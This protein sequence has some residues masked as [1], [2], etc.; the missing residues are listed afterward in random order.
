M[1]KKSSGQN[2]EKAH[3][4]VLTGFLGSGKTT[5][6]RRILSWE[7]DLSKTVILVNE[8]GD[9]GIDGLLLKNA[10]SD[11]I[12]L[13]SGCICCTLSNDLRQTLS[14]IWDQFEPRRILIETSGVSDP[15]SIAA[16]LN[17]PRFQGC[18]AL[19]KIITVLDADYWGARDAFGPLFFNQLEMGNLILLNKI[20]LLKK[21]EVPVYL[22]EIHEAFPGSQVIPTLHCAV[23]P[24]TLWMEPRPKS[25]FIKPIRFFKA[26]AL[27][28]IPSTQEIR[29]DSHD[30]S[31]EHDHA[32]SVAATDFVSF[33]FRSRQAF[34][35]TCFREFLNQLPWEVFRVKGLV[36]FMDRVLMLNF[37]G[38][39]SEWS[40]WEGEPETRLAFIGW[41]ID[42]KKTLQDLEE[43]I[44]I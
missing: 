41:G 26:T 43:C 34:D 42:G 30:D 3:V 23:D 22:K 16:V 29:E 44:R 28:A 40:T 6:L 12:E 19:K 5:L 9:V 31:K 10:G 37:V 20:D 24:E 2:P 25:V 32:E 18:M 4:M 35:E 1:E 33:S 15:K 13:T 27:T 36:R 39:K 17:E 11:I 7:T 38:G 21:D 14:R 8:F